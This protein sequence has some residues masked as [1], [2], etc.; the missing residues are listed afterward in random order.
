M[1]NLCTILNIISLWVIFTFGVILKPYMHIMVALTPHELPELV[2]RGNVGSCYQWEAAVVLPGEASPRGRHTTQQLC[3]S[4]RNLVLVV[5]EI[6]A[7]PIC[8]KLTYWR[9]TSQATDQ[10]NYLG[11]FALTVIWQLH[12]E[13]SFFIILVKIFNSEHVFLRYTPDAETARSIFI[14]IILLT[15]IPWQGVQEI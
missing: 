11:Q 12:S 10:Q 6:M 1:N 4:S 8:H 3:H 7:S 5:Q 14:W 13:K 2:Y 9:E 15:P